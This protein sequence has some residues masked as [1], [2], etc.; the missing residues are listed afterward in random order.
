MFNFLQGHG[1]KRRADLELAPARPL[2]SEEASSQ[3]RVQR[4]LTLSTVP[5]ALGPRIWAFW[6]WGGGC[7]PPPHGAA[8]PPPTPTVPGGQGWE[9]TRE[10]QAPPQRH[11]A[12]LCPPCPMWWR[13]YTAP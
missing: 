9:N 3:S 13:P 7:A 5:E 10:G 2:V 4:S 1:G 8:P 6:G 11:G 12:L